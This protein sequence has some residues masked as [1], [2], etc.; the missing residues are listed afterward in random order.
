MVDDAG[1]DLRGGEFG[2]AQH[3]ADRFDGHAIGVSNRRCESMASKVRG[4]P[5]LDTECSC[6]LL[7][8]EVVFGVAQRG[9][10]IAINAGRLILFQ[11]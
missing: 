3:L 9:Q 6:Y 5:F 11:D 7:E 2:V 1:V 10:E 8:V 4:Y